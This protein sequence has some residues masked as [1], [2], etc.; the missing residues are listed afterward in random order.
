[1]SDVHA[2]QGREN[3]SLTDDGVQEAEHNVVRD[4]IDDN[5]AGNKVVINGHEV[6]I[7]KGIWGVTT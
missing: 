6:G 3:C 7:W 2:F 1:V 5:V 4:P